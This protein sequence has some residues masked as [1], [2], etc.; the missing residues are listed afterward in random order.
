M[1]LSGLAEFGQV[2]RHTWPEV[3]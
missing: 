3:G 1:D 2:S